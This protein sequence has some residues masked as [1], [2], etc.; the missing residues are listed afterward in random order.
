MISDRDQ[1]LMTSL[2]PPSD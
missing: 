2:A 1:L